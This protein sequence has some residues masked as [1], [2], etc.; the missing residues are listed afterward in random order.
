[1]LDEEGERPQ[2]CKNRMVLWKEH[3]LRILTDLGLIPALPV[4]AWVT[5]G[6]LLNPESRFSHL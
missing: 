6:N 3:D 1:M 5:S 2:E 4:A